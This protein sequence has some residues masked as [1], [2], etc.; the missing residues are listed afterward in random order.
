MGASTGNG[1]MVL[2]FR[3]LNKLNYDKIFHVGVIVHVCLCVYADVTFFYRI[4]PSFLPCEQTKG[5]P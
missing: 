5:K 2:N 1:P 4:G 3:F